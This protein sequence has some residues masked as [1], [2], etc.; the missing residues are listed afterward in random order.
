MSLYR[1]IVTV[2]HD[3]YF[4]VGRQVVVRAVPTHEEVERSN[5][6][7]FITSVVRTDRRIAAAQRLMR[8]YMS[9]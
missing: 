2:D 8:T 5:G 9:V 1:T 7:A 3:N 6:V 4:P